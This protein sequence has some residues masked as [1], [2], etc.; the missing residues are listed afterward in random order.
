MCIQNLFESDLTVAP[1]HKSCDKCFDR[2]AP[3]LQT[4]S[5][6]SHYITVL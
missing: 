5:H 6:I 4:R 2:S 1:F 3:L